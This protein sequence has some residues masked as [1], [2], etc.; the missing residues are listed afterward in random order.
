MKNENILLT[1]HRDCTHFQST[2]QAGENVVVSVSS[3]VSISI[4]FK[5]AE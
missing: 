2:V 3:T 4:I 1:G 5:D